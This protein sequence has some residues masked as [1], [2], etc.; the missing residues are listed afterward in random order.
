MQCYHIS[1]LGVQSLIWILL[2][3]LL[4]ISF[5]L[6]HQPFYLFWRSLVCFSFHFNP[7]RA[8]HCYSF[9]LCK[10][11]QVILLLFI[12]IC[13]IEVYIFCVFYSIYG[14][15]CFAYVFTRTSFYFLCFIISAKIRWM[16]A[17]FIQFNFLFAYLHIGFLWQYLKSAY[18]EG[19]LSLL[20][21]SISSRKFKRTW[22]WE[23]A[24]FEK[25]F[26]V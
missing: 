6:F 2:P 18:V 25:N 19:N 9:R 21:N 22:T 20:L 5:F 1:L 16:C 24:L 3:P 17:Y 10:F 26:S 8:H 4:S 15:W 23:Y 13:F 7:L 12:H 11:A 14:F